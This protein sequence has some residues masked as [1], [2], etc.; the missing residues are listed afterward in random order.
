MDKNKNLMKRIFLERKRQIEN[1][2][3][4]LVKEY[5]WLGLRYL[6]FW[7][8]EVLVKT[9]NGLV[10]V[11]KASENYQYLIDLK[12]RELNTI[13]LCRQYTNNAFTSKSLPM[14]STRN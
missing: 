6:E 11:E 10:S 4:T 5:E 1:E 12:N 8:C 3:A 9:D 2:L 14:S 7:D 13:K